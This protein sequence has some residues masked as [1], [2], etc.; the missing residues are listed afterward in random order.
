[1]SKDINASRN[2]ST[3][4]ERKNHS[5]NVTKQIVHRPSEDPIGLRFAGHHVVHGYAVRQQ[6]RSWIPFSRRGRWTIFLGTLLSIVSKVYALG[7]KEE[8]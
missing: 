4:C 8:R 6:N 5:N 3:I 2:P 1:M 7:A